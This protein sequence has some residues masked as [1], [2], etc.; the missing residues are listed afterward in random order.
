MNWL[1]WSRQCFAGM[2]SRTS[3]KLR[4]MAVFSDQLT[5][6]STKLFHILQKRHI[7]VINALRLRCW[8]RNGELLLS[9]RWSNHGPARRQSRWCFWL[10]FWKCGFSPDSYGCRNLKTEKHKVHAKITFFMRLQM[11]LHQL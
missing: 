3:P 8:G 9:D 7:R 1:W 5:I 11:L 10:W 4:Q 2:E 6:K